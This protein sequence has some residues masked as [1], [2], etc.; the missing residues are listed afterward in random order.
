MT[1]TVKYSVKSIINHYDLFTYFFTQEP[2]LLDDPNFPSYPRVLIA[3]TIPG[4][5][6]S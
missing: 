5:H 2:Q 6:P 1:T 4:T 3:P